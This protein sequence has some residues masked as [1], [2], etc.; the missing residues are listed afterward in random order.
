METRGRAYYTVSCINYWIHSS[1]VVGGAFETAEEAE[2]YA[3][4]E[5]EEAEKA[6]INVWRFKVVKVYEDKDGTIHMLEW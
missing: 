4:K 2:A 6:P 5:R 1:G 3:Q